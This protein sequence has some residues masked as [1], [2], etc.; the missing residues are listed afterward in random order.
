MRGGLRAA[1]AGRGH[2]LGDDARRAHPRL[3][4]GTCGR[5]CARANA[6]SRRRSWSSATSWRCASGCSGLAPRRTRCRDDRARPHRRRRRIGLRQDHDHAGA[7]GRAGAARR[8]SAG[9]QSRARLHRSRVPCRRHRRAERQSRQLGHA[10]AAARRARGRGGAR[11]RAA[12][13]RRRHG[14]V[15]R[16]AG[17][18]R[19]LGR[20][21]RLGRALS[22]CRCCSCSTSR[23][24][25]RSA[26]AVVRG[27]LRSRPRGPHRRR[28]CST[29]SAASGIAAGRRCR[30]PRS[31]CRWSARCRATRRSRCPSAI[32]AWCRRASTPIS[33]RVSTGSLTWR[34]AHLDLDAVIASAAP[35]D[36]RPRRAKLRAAAARPTH[37]A[38][39]R[40]RL[41]VRLS[42]Y[43]RRAGG[44]PARRSSAFSPLADEPPP[45]GCDCCW[46]PGGYPEL[47]AGALAARSAFPRR[48][49]AVCRRP[50]RSTASAAATW[51]WAK[52][53]RTPTA[54]ATP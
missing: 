11:R 31:A 46:L 22:V 35:L 50:A 43:P 54:S 52:A 12:G 21:R 15:R 38:R 44:G 49:R 17:T 36:A 18:T 19:P 7:A 34:S 29:A 51:C 16:R 32:S 6:S 47:H 10:A 39:V 42:A 30:S 20:D 25:R 3:D 40:R 24:S 2:C 8:G 23:H 5:R 48:A 37:R 13:D 4:A 1:N 9:G 14:P 45:D 53:S 41:H 27:F 26:A 33:P 28:S